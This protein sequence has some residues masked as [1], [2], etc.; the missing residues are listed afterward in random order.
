MTDGRD[1]DPTDVLTGGSETSPRAWVG[2]L[3]ALAVVGGLAWVTWGPGADAPDDPAAVPAAPTS[4]TPDQ[5]L[6][7]GV[8]VLDSE[9]AELDPGTVVTVPHAG[10]VPQDVGA[11]RLGAAG[12]RTGVRDVLIACWPAGW[13]VDQRPV[14]GESLLAGDVVTLTVTNDVSARQECPAGVATETDRDLAG[15][16]IAFAQHPGIGDPLPWADDLEVETPDGSFSV[17]GSAAHGSPLWAEAPLDAVTELGGSVVV[18]AT[19]SGR[20]PVPA[21]FEEFRRL[22]ISAP[23]GAAESPF[24]TSSCE[25]G[26][27]AN[28][29]VDLEGAIRGVQLAGVQ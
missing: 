5:E 22:A 29:F 17:G 15:R 21:Q 3:V 8:D 4:S 28:L 10:D 24:R 26:Q 14:P 16:F 1:D 27:A 9:V 13:V 23:R 20:C 11:A 2:A 12:L 7:P 25:P 19:A 6:E 18:R